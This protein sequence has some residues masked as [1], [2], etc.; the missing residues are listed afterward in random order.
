MELHMEHLG[1]GLQ[2][3]VLGMGLVFALLALLW[4][5][6]TVVLK[7]DKEEEPAPEVGAQEATVEAEHIAAIADDAVGAQTPERPTVNGMPADL[8]AAILT[9][10]YKHR[11][12][13]RRQAAPL[14]RAVAPGSQLFASRWLAAG[15]ARQTHNWQPGG[16]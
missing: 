10:A 13:L 3:T 6:L 15:R 1:W 14:T 12:T 16:R 4:L 8:V 9:A 5:L 11:Q 2:M 7:L